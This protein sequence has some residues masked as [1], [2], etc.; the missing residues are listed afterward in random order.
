MSE[1]NQSEATNWFYRLIG[2]IWWHNFHELWI[3]IICIDA[4]RNGCGH[5]KIIRLPV[6]RRQIG[7][8]GIWRRRFIP[9]RWRRRWYSQRSKIQ[10]TWRR[11]SNRSN[12]AD[13]KISRTMIIVVIAIYVVIGMDTNWCNFLHIHWFS[14]MRF[15]CARF[16]NDAG[17]TRIVR[18]H[19]HAVDWF[20]TQYLL[21]RT[22]ETT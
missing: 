10:C 9:S 13:I 15:K 12:I 21:A 18:R 5:R 4:E 7:G 17:S 1:R 11:W 3:S 22:C 16:A 20:G 2:L 8:T 6:D 19:C 14:I